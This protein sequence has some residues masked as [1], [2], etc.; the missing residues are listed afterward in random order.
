MDQSWSIDFDKGIVGWWTEESSKF[1]GNM[2]LSGSL[3]IEK[4]G[5]SIGREGIAERA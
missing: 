1:W 4:A 2:H 5:I 3:C